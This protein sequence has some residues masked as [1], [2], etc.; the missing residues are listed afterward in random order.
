[1]FHYF[2]TSFL[3]FP[4]VMVHEF[5]HRIA[6]ALFGVRVRRAV[7]FRFGNP[8]GYVEHDTPRTYFAHFWI[9]SAPLFLNTFLEA[10]IV[11][12]LIKQPVHLVLW[13]VIVLAWVAFSLGVHAIPSDGDIKNILHVT[14][15]PKSFFGFFA[16]ILMFPIVAIVWVADT[17]KM[18]G[19]EIVYA[20]AVS[21]GVAYWLLHSNT[22][23][24]DMLQIV[25]F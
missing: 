4:G 18:F 9:S 16:G 6:C 24:R 11:F 8:L 1:M 7:Y 3:T 23:V 21:G 20:L 17:L 2:I 5:A 12:V 13:Q 14:R 10:C 22:T 19:F 15:H 25:G